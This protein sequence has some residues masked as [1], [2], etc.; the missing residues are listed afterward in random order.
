MD[1]GLLAVVTL[2]L[3]Q[4]YQMSMRTYSRLARYSTRTS[5]E[6]SPLLTPREAFHTT[7]STLFSKLS[8]SGNNKNNGGRPNK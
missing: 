6:M 8:K 4:R 1:Q 3:F 2:L 7:R 5:R